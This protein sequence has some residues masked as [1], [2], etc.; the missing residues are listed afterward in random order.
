MTDSASGRGRISPNVRTVPPVKIVRRRHRLQTGAGGKQKNDLHAAPPR[1]FRDGFFYAPPQSRD[2]QIRALA[3]QK[4]L[5][6]FDAARLAENYRG[7]AAVCGGETAYAVK[8]NPHPAVLRTLSAAGASAF[9][10][11]SLAEIRAVRAANPQAK[12]YFMHPVKAPEA[13]AEAYTVWGVRAFVLDHIDEL[14]KILRETALAPDL[15]LFVR[16]ALPKN[17]AAALDFSSKFGATPDEAAKLLEACRPVCRRLGLAFHTGTQ[18]TDTGTYTRAV[19][20]AADVI[21]KSGVPVDALDAG[22]GFPANYTG[23][24]AAPAEIFAAL[25]TALAENGLDDLDL[26]T[27]PGRVLV[28]DTTALIVRVEQR[29][30]DL[31]YLNDGVYGGLFD[32][33]PQLRWRYPVRH[34][35]REDGTPVSGHR[36]NFRFAG[37]TCD[38]IDMMDGPFPLPDNIKTGDWIE[39]GQAGAYSQSLRTDFNG[40]GTADFICAGSLPRKTKK[41]KTTSK[42]I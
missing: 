6:I 32:A 40:F 20:A 19:A 27:E 29:R 35:P 30:G 18:N 14:Y 8:C 36:T 11:A 26:I 1:D 2:M 33:G 34:I 16:M 12:L 22:G 28:A 23:R 24:V 37:P 9:D 41:P 38:S 42:N 15:E 17:G 13:I 21:A 10:V 4:P 7:F 31:L 3:P 39:I 25:H 5:Y